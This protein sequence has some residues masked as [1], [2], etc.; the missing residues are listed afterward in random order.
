MNKKLISLS[1]LIL[2]LQSNVVYCGQGWGDWF[3]A[4]FYGTSQAKKAKTVIPSSSYSGGAIAGMGVATGGLFVGHGVESLSWNNEAWREISQ[5]I[6]IFTVYSAV[7]M[8]MQSTVNRDEKID[9]I[10]SW[11]RVVL[12]N[13]LL[14]PTRSS[15]LHVLLK[16]DDFLQYARLYGYDDIFDEVCR[17]LS[18]EISAA[19]YSQEEK[20]QDRQ[21]DS[22]MAGL[23]QGLMSASDLSQQIEALEAIQNKQSSIVAMRGYLSIYYRLKNQLKYEEKLTLEQ[24]QKLYGWRMSNQQV[25]STLSLEELGERE[26][27]WKKEQEALQKTRD[28]GKKYKDKSNAELLDMSKQK[29]LEMQKE[30]EKSE[31]SEQQKYFKSEWR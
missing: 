25:I 19:T 13:S 3:R 27:T 24:K 9:Y 16:K 29:A 31:Q 14:Y 8:I 18:A 22:Y 10:G 1:C 11:I 23:R 20:E 28:A 21:I 6:V 4:K 5:G 17:L 26:G 15:K 2:I 30:R 12:N 7:S